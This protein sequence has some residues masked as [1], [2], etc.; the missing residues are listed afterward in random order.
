MRANIL[1]GV[2]V[3]VAAVVAAV[4]V[5]ALWPA[6]QSEDGESI[7]THDTQDMQDSS[8]L[9]D[10]A[11]PPINPDAPVFDIVR[12]EPGGDAVIAG[13]SPSNAQISLL[14]DGERFAEVI[15]DN[16]GEWTLMTRLPVGQMQ[17]SLLARLVDGREIASDQMVVINVP[18]DDEQTPLVVLH[19]EGEPSRI[20]QDPVQLPREGDLFLE[21]LDYSESGGLILSGGGSA[22]STVRFYLDDSPLGATNVN[23]EGRWTFQVESGVIAPGLHALR[24]DQIDE[25]GEVV[26]RIELPF[27]QA[28]QEIIASLRPG[29][30]IVQP[31]N[32]LWRISRRV[33]GQGT[34]YTIIYE[35]NAEQI[36]DP[37]LIYPGQIFELPTR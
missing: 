3:V 31:G 7:E 18:E 20:L 30:V 9:P 28:D 32:S 11:D 34:D 36:R 22:D 14:V 15:A 16:R 19:Q 17:L 13:R 1:I 21:V 4:I 24:L 8:D 5:G 37:D 33:Y 12:V 29:E 23:A 2:I 6:G 26:A 27:E 35:A 10:A 25:N